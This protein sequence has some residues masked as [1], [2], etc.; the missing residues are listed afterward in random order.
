MRPAEQL[1]G[2]ELDNGWTVVELIKRPPTATGG[3][4]PFGYCVEN[5]DGRQ[6]FM[7]AMDYMGALQAKNT[8]AEMQVLTETYLFEKRICERCR[9]NNLS[10]VLHAIDSGSVLADATNPAG[11]VEY[12]IFD[13]ADSDIRI[14]LDAQ[15]KF[16]L[17]FALRALHNVAVG[18]EQLHK[19]EMAHQDLKPSNVLVFPHDVGSKVGDLGRAWCKELS[20]PHDS[21]PIAGDMGYAPPELLYSFVL[22]DERMRRFACDMY[23]FGSMAVFV[24]ARTHMTALLFPRLSRQHW[25]HVW[26]DGYEKVMPYLQAAFA[27][28]LEVFERAVTESVQ[29][30]I[31][32]IVEYACNPD[33]NSRG[34][35]LARKYIGNSYSFERFISTLDLL[36]RR[37]EYNLIH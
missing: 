14:H 5:E 35:P 12:L 13:L 19:G 6:G 3:H 28:S 33:P 29:S 7:K 30:D 4:F 20:A 37:A 8:L 22:P 26:A 2:V 15:S 34:H 31:R 10:R 11:K 36:A 16:D 24:F 32:K 18:L 27:E 25:P 21:A 23:H 9:D 17:A 1:A